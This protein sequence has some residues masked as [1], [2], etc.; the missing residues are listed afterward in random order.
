MILTEPVLVEEHGELIGS[1]VL[2]PTEHLVRISYLDFVH[3]SVH[4][5]RSYQGILLAIGNLL[6]VDSFLGIDGLLGS[7][8]ME[9]FE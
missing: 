1:S 5:F 9:H 2:R 4:D 3:D 6:G 7:G 8:L